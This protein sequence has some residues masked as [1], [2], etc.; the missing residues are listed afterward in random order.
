MTG[1]AHNGCSRNLCEEELVS[2][3]LSPDGTQKVVVLLQ[4]CGAT[5]KYTTHV[6]VW[7][8]HH[9]VPTTFT[10]EGLA[11]IICGGVHIEAAWSS[12][13]DVDLRYIE[14]RDVCGGRHVNAVAETRVHVTRVGNEQ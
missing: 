8:A 5:T 12:D 1:L 3:T 2:E 11:M 7:P 4:N 14:P 13:H 10:D 6:H 9:F